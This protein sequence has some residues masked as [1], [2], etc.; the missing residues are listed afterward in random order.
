MG[1]VNLASM[2]IES[3]IPFTIRGLIYLYGNL[4]LDKNIPFTTNM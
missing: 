1:C 2:V 3:Q 4:K